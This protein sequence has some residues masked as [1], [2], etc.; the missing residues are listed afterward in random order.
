ML[1][2]WAGLRIARRIHNL[3]PY[4]STLCVSLLLAVA[5]R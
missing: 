1:S 5:V 3:F 2:N 4:A